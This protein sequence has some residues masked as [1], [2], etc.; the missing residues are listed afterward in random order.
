MTSPESSAILGSAGAVRR[1][2]R[3]G[4][5]GFSGSVARDRLSTDDSCPTGFGLFLF[6]TAILFIRPAEIVPDLDGWPIYEAA[7]VLCLAASLPAVLRQLTWR[8]LKSAPAKLCVIGILPAIL[9]SHLRHGDTYYARMDGL[10]FLKILV[11]FLL[12]VG[13]LTN[14]RRIDVFVWMLLVF[15]AVI[16]VLSVLTYRGTLQISGL[17]P[18][19][20]GM[21]A[22]AYGQSLEIPRLQGPGIFN[23]PNDFSLILVTGILIAAQFFVERRQFLTRLSCVGA[24]AI[25]LYA[26]FLTRSR[27][28]LLSLIAGGATFLF[29]RYPW[30][31]ALL[32]L[33]IAVP[34][35]LA[36]I[37]GRQT[38]IN[39]ENNDDT[40]Q[41]RIQLWRDSLVLFHQSPIFGIGCNRLADITGLVA[42]N[43]YVQGYTEIGLIGGTLF[44]GAIYIPLW[45]LG[46]LR[47]LIRRKTPTQ[48][49][50]WTGCIMAVLVGYAVGMFSLTRNY[51]VSTYVIIGLAVAF[52]AV[53]AAEHPELPAIK[54]KV[55]IRRVAMVSMGMLIILEFFARFVAN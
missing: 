26:F 36:L 20:Q 52:A 30:R 14:H 5:A 16:A 45:E 40:A 42:H 25:I 46:R 55:L 15:I 3:T 38:N 27:G 8:S 53:M 23:D 19:A 32:I 13:L 12:L 6:L 37:G 41:G 17:N 29:C 50:T 49:G 1:G 28:G 35:A 4:S 33:T 21:G 44:V 47:Q 7:I 51:M 22:D 9:L 2:A 54:P 34:L 39:L 31:R 43:S 11:Y 24:S 18:V 48:W 10:G